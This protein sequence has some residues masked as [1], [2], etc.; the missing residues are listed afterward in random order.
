MGPSFVICLNHIYSP[1]PLFLFW[2]NWSFFGCRNIF[3]T[4]LNR[5]E[6]TSFWSIYCVMSWSLRWA[7]PS[8]ITLPR[9]VACSMPDSGPAPSPQRAPLTLVRTCHHCHWTILMQYVVELLLYSSRP[10][11]L[12]EAPFSLSPPP[13]GHCPNSN[14][15]PPRTQTG[16][17]GHFFQARFY[18]FLPFLPFFT[19]FTI[20]LPFFLWISAPNHPGKG[21]DPPKIKQMPLWTWKILL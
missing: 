12:R 21:L 9:A 5:T 19:L 15:T 14:Y 6:F 13:C 16:T 8:G 17:L 10:I 2:P 11:L 3:V 7:S 18:H 4:S 20:F 1:H